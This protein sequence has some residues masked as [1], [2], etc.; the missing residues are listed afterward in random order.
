MLKIQKRH[1]APATVPDFTKP[2]ELLVRCH[3]RIES[4]L[5]VL[6]R[7]TAALRAS[8]EA[9]EEAIS[10]IR[11]AQAH[12]AGPGVK[13]TE[14]EEIS[15]FPRMRSARRLLE[16]SVLEGLDALESEHREADRVHGAFDELA[17]GLRHSSLLSQ[18]KV[19]SLSAAVSALAALYRPHISLENG[20]IY[21]AAARVLSAEQLL[22]IGEEMRE[23][24]KDM[25]TKAG[26]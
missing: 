24:R 8:P 2:L 10:A 4:A 5:G 23:R 9:S 18:S 1:A 7:A 25:S 15:L 17:V 13:H 11:A 14:D 22:T 3:E 12:F 26:T 21:P 16:A 6:E 19:A 20:L